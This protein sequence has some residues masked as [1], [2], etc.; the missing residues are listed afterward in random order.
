[1]IDIDSLRLNYETTVANLAKRGVKKADIDRVLALDEKWR[2]LTQAVEELRA[3]KNSA[4][5]AVAKAASAAKQELIA[6]MKKVAEQEETLAA[7]QEKIEEER[8]QAWRALPNLVQSDVPEGGAEDFEIVH[9]GPTPPQAASRQDYFSLAEPHLLDLARAAKVSG[10][11]FVYIKGHLARLQLALVSYVFDTLMA[12][13]FMPI[14]PPVLISEQAMSGMG[15]MEQGSDE[16]YRTQDNLYLVGTSEQ[17]L[18]P[19]HMNETLAVGAGPVRYVAFSTCFRREAGS[20]GK[21]VRGILRLHQFDKVEMFSF[22]APAQGAAE[23]EYLLSLQQQLV[24]ALEL[25]YRVIKLAAGDLGAPSA[26]TYDV[27]TWIPSEGRYRETHSTS[28]TT[29]YQARRLNIRVK[30]QAG[31]VHKAHLLNGTALAMSRTFIALLEN[32]QQ[33]DGAIAIPAVLHSYL[34]FTTI[35]APQK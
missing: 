21:D 17:A 30:D 18:G 3:Q 34:P 16:I 22:A 8:R 12:E 6:A 32:H 29:D 4:N 15:Y 24:E 14:L 19:L 2:E 20:H 31:M 28:N 26:K 7:E 23:H 25:P 13:G 9:E 11:R 1:M 27:E 33:P 5:A 35:P 10:S